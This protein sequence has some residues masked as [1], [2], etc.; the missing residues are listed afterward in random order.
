MSKVTIL[1]NLKRNLPGWK[2][3]IEMIKRAGHEVF[4]PGERDISEDEAIHYLK[5]AEAV[6]VGLNRLSGNVIRSSKYLKVIAKPGIGVDNIDIAAA[7]QEGIIVCNTPGSNAESVADHLFGL[8]IA[9]A[10]RLP[11]LDRLTRDGKGWEFHPAVI[12]VEIGG[13]ILGVI[14]T[15]HIGKAVIRR[16][17]GFNMEILAYDIIQ[18]AKLINDFFVKYLPLKDV[19]RN[20]DFVTLHIPLN[21]KTYHMIGEEELSLMKK[22]AF[23]FNTSRG[24]IVDEKALV[25]ALHEGQIAGAGIDVFEQEPIVESELFK[26]ENIIVTPHVAGFSPEASYRSRIMSAEN[27]I[28]ALKGV[29]PYIVNREVLTLPKIRIRLTNH[30]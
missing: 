18:D 11:Y 3:A 21:D 23:L 17:K 14:G 1:S 20:A 13:K 5:E 8:M 25:K 26:F 7:T 29:E 6:L 19:L 12:G 24:S 27:I 9:V 28:K 10:R 15:G 30:T 4:D 16:A 22:T 2:E